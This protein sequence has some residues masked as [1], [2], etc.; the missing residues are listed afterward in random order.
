MSADSIM[1]TH[2]YFDVAGNLIEAHNQTQLGHHCTYAAEEEKRRRRA[3]L[4]KMPRADSSW[5]HGKKLPA[6]NQ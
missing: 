4:G 1:E 2:I 6:G 5:I 3:A